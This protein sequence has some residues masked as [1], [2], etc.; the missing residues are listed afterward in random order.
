M[1]INPFFSGFIKIHILYHASQ[2][3]IFGLEIIKELARHG[4]HVS[5]G[6]V[7]PALH[8]LEKEGLLSST[9]QVV[10]G[11]VRRYYRCTPAGLKALREIKPKLQELV[12]EVLA[13]S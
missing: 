8:A 9:P 4:Y 13:G 12:Q 7:Y 10:G 1:R 3:P 2:G 11:K 5:P 6:T